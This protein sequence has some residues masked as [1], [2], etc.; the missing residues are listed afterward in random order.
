MTT[1]QI[2]NG[3]IP[4]IMNFPDLYPDFLTEVFTGVPVKK[5]RTCQFSGLKS[6]DAP[7]LGFPVLFFGRH[8]V[9]HHGKAFCRKGGVLQRFGE[10]GV[11]ILRVKAGKPGFGGEP[12]GNGRLRKKDNG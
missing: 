10:V 7:K 5:D 4:L 11:G 2:I 12:S 1:C 6:V 3:I 8:V 9:L